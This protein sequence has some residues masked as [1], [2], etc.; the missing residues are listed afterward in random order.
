MTRP[1]VSVGLPNPETSVS[2]DV[3]RSTAFSV[4]ATLAGVLILTTSGCSTFSAK[5]LEAQYSPSEGI[6]ETVAVLRRHVSDNTY[7]FPPAN[8]FSGRNVYRA[9]LLRLESLER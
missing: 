8:D 4:L 5:Q 7:R 9:S 6:L 1:Q 2:R 3:A